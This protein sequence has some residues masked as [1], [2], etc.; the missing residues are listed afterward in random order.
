MLE[1]ESDRIINLQFTREAFRTE[2]GPV[3]EERRAGVEDDPAG[4][5]SVELYREAYRQHTYQHP[6]IGWKKDLEET[7]TFEDGLEFKNRFY[8]PNNCVLVIAGNVS[9]DSALALVRKHYSSWERGEP[10]TPQI[11]EEPP[12]TEERIKN[13]VWKDDQIS[14][15][16]QIGYH[17][18]SVRSDLLTITTLRVIE[19]ILFSG[20]GRATRL[21][22]HELNL[23]ESISSDV[24]MRKDPGLFVIFARL[25]GSHNLEQVRDS[26]YSQLEQLKNSTISEEEIRKAVNN[27]RA[28]M[29]YNLDRPARVAGSIGFYHLIAGDYKKMMEIYQLY[30]EV[31]PE[32]IRNVTE[33]TFDQFNRTLVTLIPSSAS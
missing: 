6:V 28:N 1:I 3:K 5:L 8:V 17:I 26:I 7:M 23:V 30:D 9:H 22:K 19:E 4:F 27:L 33:K 2:L 32:Q 13:F 29:I 11:E 25:Q 16:I 21:L 10:Y 14:P 18:P 15:L 24:N 20:S 12:Q 31:T